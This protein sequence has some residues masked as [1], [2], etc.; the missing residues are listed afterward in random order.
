MN[1]PPSPLAAVIGDPAAIPLVPEPLDPD[2]IVAGEPTVLDGPIRVS[3]DGRVLAGVWKVSPGTFTDVMIGDE[4][5]V[6]LE[7]TAT[8]VGDDG[9]VLDLAPGSICVFSEGYRS[10]WTVHTTLF[11]VY[12]ISSSTRIG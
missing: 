3:S 5:F 8:I 4:M 9:A 2:S 7:G 6:V 10:T 1:P 12:Q 11:K